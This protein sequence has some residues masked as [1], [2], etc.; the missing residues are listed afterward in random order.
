MER[1]R[2]FFYSGECP[3]IRREEMTEVANQYFT[4]TFVITD[5][6]IDYQWIIK[7]TRSWVESRLVNTVYPSDYLLIT[8]GKKITL[9]SRNLFRILK[10]PPKLSYPNTSTVNMIL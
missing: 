7:I 2:E 1:K 9:Q 10:W 3:L 5:Y 8:M 4:I 6:S